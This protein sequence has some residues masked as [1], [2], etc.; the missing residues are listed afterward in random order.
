M[1]RRE[2]RLTPRNDAVHRQD[3]V[4]TYVHDGLLTFRP[5]ARIRGVAPLAPTYP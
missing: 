3:G 1:N 4:V 2:G 5:H